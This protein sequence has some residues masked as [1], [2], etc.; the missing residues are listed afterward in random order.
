MG[1]GIYNRAISTENRPL[2]GFTVGVRE[3][4]QGSPT[5]KWVSQEKHHL[6]NAMA[7]LD[8]SRAWGLNASEIM[9]ESKN[10]MD[11]GMKN[12]ALYIYIYN[13]YCMYR[14]AYIQTLCAIYLWLASEKPG[15]SFRG[16]ITRILMFWGR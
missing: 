10:R 13:M 8:V 16:P 2:F 9:R 3:R 15:D 1:K 14:Y 12:P 11:S 5:G 7:K 4:V 6:A